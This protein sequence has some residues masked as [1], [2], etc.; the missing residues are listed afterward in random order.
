M[1]YATIEASMLILE[2]EKFT[3]SKILLIFLDAIAS[4]DWGYESKSARIISL[5]Y[6]RCPK[7]MFISELCALLANEHFFLDTLYKCNK[8]I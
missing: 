1:F 8:C 2:H 5:K 7:K 4:L 3:L 6:T